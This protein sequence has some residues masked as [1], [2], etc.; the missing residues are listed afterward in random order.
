VTFTPQILALIDKL[1]GFEVVRD[2]IAAILVCESANQVALATTAGKPDP[3]KWALRVFT[4]RS[5][6]WE[7]L[8]K[9]EN[10]TSDGIPVVNVWYDNS[11]FDASASNIV[12]RQR[13]NGTF[14]VDVYAVGVA[15]TDGG[16]GHIAG[17]EDAARGLHAAIR[18]VRNILMAGAYTYLGLPRGTVGKRWLQSVTSFQPST[19][20]VR[21]E[22]I[23]AARLS[24]QIDFNELSPQVQG[25]P[26]T[27]LSL[28]VRRDTV[29]G[30]VLFAE[31]VFTP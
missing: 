6:P 16:T 15:S 7:I 11:Q 22:N 3:T 5:D 17:D 20:G 29:T 24:F 30:E 21:V 28:S 23:H 8:Q 9:E 14:N 1:D 12:E 31:T 26:V 19:D 4:E 27:T 25:Q 10:P 2:Q 13:A 18:M